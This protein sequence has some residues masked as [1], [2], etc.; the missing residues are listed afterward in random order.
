MSL[1][2]PPDRL[3]SLSP[4][5]HAAAFRKVAHHRKLTVALCMSHSGM[6]VLRAPPLVKL[7]PWLP[8]HTI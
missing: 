3:Q 1:G 8:V 2:L 6:P 5:L 4:L 7:S